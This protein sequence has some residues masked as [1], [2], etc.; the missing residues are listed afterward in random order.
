MS[1]D[2]DIVCYHDQ[3]IELH[4][5]FMAGQTRHCS[6]RQVFSSYGSF[7][8]FVA[9]SISLRLSSDIGTGLRHQSGWLQQLSAR[10]GNE[11]VVKQATARTEYGGAS[12]IWH[13]FWQEFVV[14]T[15]IGWT[16][17]SVSHSDFVSWSS[18]IYDM[19]PPYLSELCWQTRNLEGRRQLRSATRGDLNV[20]I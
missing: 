16:Y 11:G 13:K 3:Q 4:R 18:T 7:V 17:L 1:N 6:Q 8:E 15:Y 10:W 5:T 19:A 2:L 20:P 9:R 12:C 14:T